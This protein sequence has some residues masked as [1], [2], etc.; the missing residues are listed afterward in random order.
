MSNIISK[1]L[2]YAYLNKELQ[3]YLIENS[4]PNTF[5][6]G[7]LIC[8]EGSDADSVLF[9]LKGQIKSVFNNKERI[10][11]PSA[12]CI[13]Q[14]YEKHQTTLYAEKNSLVL[15]V[16]LS[17]SQQDSLICWQFASQ[18]LENQDWFVQLTEGDMFDHIP[19]ANLYRLALAF[20][21]KLATKDEILIREDAFEKEFYVLLEGT[22]GIFRGELDETNKPLSQLEPISHLGEAG[23]IEMLPRTAS[24]KMLE[25]GKL[26]VLDRENLAPLLQDNIDDTAFIEASQLKSLLGEGK[27]KIVD[28]RPEQ[29]RLLSPIKTDKQ[30]I[31]NSSIEGKQNIIKDIDDAMQNQGITHF[32]IY[33]PYEQ[34]NKLCYQWLKQSTQNIYILK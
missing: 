4:Q 16:H 8:R 31:I 21:E 24:G 12:L 13:S 34:L 29:Q 15:T 17:P 2:P 5:K 9:L 14:G 27:T 32:V 1:L 23:L 28:I 10:K 22:I 30:V 11:G 25:E 33:S 3:D 18:L 19:S 7:D 20:E 6:A 26:M